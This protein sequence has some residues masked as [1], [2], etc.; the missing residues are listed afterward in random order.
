MGFEQREDKR[1]K[2]A[3]EWR[4]ETKRVQENYMETYCLVTRCLALVLSALSRGQCICI[5]NMDLS[6][7]T[8]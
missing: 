3:R 5:E 1:I 6:V 4:S 2:E 7:L 8:P